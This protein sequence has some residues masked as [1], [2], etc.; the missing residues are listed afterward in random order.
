MIP[1]KNSLR[2]QVR[3]ATRS[4]TLAERERQS[5]EVFS[6]LEESAAFRGAR[7][8]ALFWSLPDEI[9]SHDF[10]RRWALQKRIVLPVVQGD[11]MDFRLLDPDVPMRTGAYGISEPA[12]EGVV[13]R[14]EIDLIVVPGVAFDRQGYRCGRGKGYYDRYL[15]GAVLHKTGVCFAHQLY[16]SIPAQAW[17]VAMDEVIAWAEEE[18]L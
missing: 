1:D 2:A 14:E 5:M 11:E 9:P 18:A 16:N 6:R 7:T 17:D 13:P 4:L 15:A 10:V 8:V 12:A 3:T